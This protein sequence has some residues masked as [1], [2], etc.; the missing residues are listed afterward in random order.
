MVKACLQLL[1][2]KE[3]NNRASDI[4]NPT[5]GTCFWL[6][7]HEKYL[8]SVSSKHSLLW[9]KG[10][11][12]AG[13]STVLKYG[14]QSMKRNS[15]SETVI[16]AFFF[17]GRGSQIQKDRHG[18][19]RSLC[20]QIFNQFPDSCSDLFE[21]FKE[22]KEVIGPV[23]EKW[24]WQ[25]K[26]LS[27]L[28]Q[29]AMQKVLT[30][31][32]VC[33]FKDALD[34]SGEATAIEL[35]EYFK[36]L[37]PRSSSASSQNELHICFSCQHYPILDLDDG[38]E[39]EVERENN[40][41]IKRYASEKL[42]LQSLKNGDREILQN[43]ILSRSRGIF[44]WVELVIPQLLRARRKGGSLQKILTQLHDIPQEIREICQDILVDLKTEEP[45]RSPQLLRWLCFALRPLSITELLVAVDVSSR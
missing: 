15:S 39:I 26:K 28:F 23:G 20:H 35:I 21:R 34:E 27:E 1:A 45:V 10:H 31:R 32:R 6:L 12:G 8:K 13:K 29:V 7:K 2:F 33:L 38:L 18:L 37:L 24:D 41:D 44:L 11:P 16:L 43:E 19:F 22:R 42:Q 14:L 3:M 4:S 17:H 30:R 36:K 5:E 25:H 40:E 9:I